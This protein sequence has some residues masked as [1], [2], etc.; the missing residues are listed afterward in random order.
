MPTMRRL[1]AGLALL[2]LLRVAT[3]AAADD[4]AA[5]AAG[6]AVAGIP[7]CT[8]IIERAGEPPA[9]LADA[10]NP[11]G[12]LYM[13]QNQPERALADLD[14][15]LRLDPRHAE[16]RHN[17]G[18]ALGDPGALPGSAR[19]AR[20]GDPPRPERRGREPPRAGPD[21][22]HVDA[23]ISRGSAYQMRGQVDRAM[24]DFTQAIRLDP[25]NADA[26]A[27][28]G[29]L[30]LLTNRLAQAGVDLDRAIR[31]DPDHGTAYLNRGVTRLFQRQFAR[32]IA[33]FDQALRVHPQ[34]AH[35]LVQ[36]GTAYLLWQQPGRALADA[37]EALRLD[38]NRSVAYKL[39]ATALAGLGRRGQAIADFRKALE[40]DPADE[41]V[42]Q[43]LRDMGVA[44]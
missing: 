43:S 1:A 33:D 31:P 21:P 18:A 15:A 10:Y 41:T 4:T 35:L 42:R 2:A 11:G 26:H 44:P 23:L 37:N 19:R 34:N 16:A 14:E 13:T 28:R 30:Y 17:R 9:R 25:R 22:R 5:C 20:G 3:L 40:L 8:R 27:S 38:P 6:D 12:K 32:A 29:A 39:R 24:V 36:R 7:A